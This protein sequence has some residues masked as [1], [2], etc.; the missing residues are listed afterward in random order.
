MGNLHITKAVPLLILSVAIVALAM[1]LPSTLPELRAAASVKQPK[2]AAVADTVGRSKIL[3]SALARKKKTA[4]GASQ[5]SHT[6]IAA[7]IA[8]QTDQ[9]APIVPPITPHLE[10]L[11]SGVSM[12]DQH[13]TL[14]RQVLSLLTPECQDKLETF[15]VL[16]N[17]PKN[18]GLAGR[19]VIIVSGAV[20]DQEF[21]G[22]LLH[23]G[24][25]H[26]RD[27]TC[28]TGNPESGAS[29]FR[30]GQ[31]QIWND[32]PSVLFYKISWNSEHQRK[33]DA[34][35]ED[36]VT[37]YAYQ[38]DNFEDLAESVTYFMTQEQAFR[39]RAKSNPILA[40]K[41]AWLESYMPKQSSVAEGSAWTGE[42]PW[43]AT[44]IAFRWI[45]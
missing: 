15:S 37:G 9:P 30:D 19:G 20:P 25:G 22:L 42:I 31:A 13:R 36:F 12:L 32:D 17:H 3:Q 18:R 5:L 16:Y 23:E 29:P 44:K 2:P 39:E 10:K 45:L 38:A 8:A 26:F 33:D 6:M 28:V 11:L 43:D 35:P 4:P 7:L 40:V 1:H 34:R 27:I 24:L 21:I 14:A 41:L